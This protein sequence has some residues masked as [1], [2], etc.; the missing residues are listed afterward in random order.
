MNAYMQRIVLIGIALICVAEPLL[1][2]RRGG[3]GGMRGGGGGMRGGGG[4]GFGSRG[5]ARTSVSGGGF[6]GGGF[7]GGGINRP[8]AGGGNMNYGN[9]NTG[10]INRGNINT[11]NI[12]RGNINVNRPV[13]LNDVDVHGGYYG[14]GYGCCYHPIGAAAAI[15]TAAAITAAAIGS[16]AYSLPSSCTVVVV[17][18]ISYEQCGNTWYQPQFMGSETTYIVVNPPR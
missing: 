4:G 14:G 10:N 15:G 3:G 17:G 16:V 11:G 2:Q 6:G 13:N 12:N 1:A 8:G 9:I 5:G 7:G 18:G